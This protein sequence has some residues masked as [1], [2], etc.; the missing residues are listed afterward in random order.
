[1]KK[2]AELPSLI[3][4]ALA[5]FACTA[6]SLAQQ[7]DWPA[8]GATSGNSHYSSLAQINRSNAASLKESWRFDTGEAGGLETTPLVIDG[9][10]YGLTPSKKVFAIDA[11][12]GRQIWKFDSGV[13]APSASRGLNWW[14]S[15]KENRLLVGIANFLYAIDPATGKPIASFGTDGRIDL[16]EN[17][18]RPPESQSVSLN[19]P[20]VVYKDLI[21]V[22]SSLPE[23]IPAPPGD[24]RAYDVRTGAL[25]WSFHTIPHPGEPGYQTWSPDSWKT[26]GAANNWAGMALDAERG[27]V[28]VPTGS[29]V[30]DFYG[31][32]R[33]GDDLYANTLLALDATTG[34]LLWHF[35]GVHHD[36][37]DRDFPAPP[38]LLTVRRNGK[39]IPAVAQTTKQGILFVFDRV[40][41]KPI[42][43]IEERPVLASDIPG[44]VAAKTQPYPSVPEAFAPQTVTEANLTN[45]TPAAHA[46]AVERLRQVRSDGPYVPLSVGKDTLVTPSFE[47]G[48]EWGGPASDPSTGVVYINANNYA[49]LGML[50]SS[51]SDLP[52]RATY[53]SQCSVCHGDHRQG[54]P[55][56]F[57]SLNAV[58]KRLT[59]AQIS[60]TIHHGKGRMP[61]FPIEGRQLNDL[62]SYLE[63]TESSLEKPPSEQQGETSSAEKSQQK[64]DGQYT[65]TG[66]RRFLDPD[67]YPATATPWG[68]LNAIDLNTGKYLWK[69]PLGQYPEL[70]AQGL[71]DT[72]SENYGGPIVTA[73]GLLFIAATNFDHKIRAFDKTT[74]KLLWESTMP[75]AGN[76]T[77]VTYMVHG[78]QYIAIAAGGSSMNPRGP[79]GGVYIAFALP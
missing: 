15:G 12:T 63:T 24:I 19:S 9:V 69:L 26:S 28:Y 51:A 32:G 11:A 22:G 21:I 62:L 52:G 23:S 18:G 25:R 46:W 20:G 57:P 49:S 66:Y 48:A 16:R 37:W 59:A 10:L 50:I 34:K 43:P 35:Q 54:E 65:I 29:A 3:V 76:A 38:I 31:A 6:V 60:D 44:E 42:F 79:T 33:L 68:S 71:P 77:P 13:K 58:G 40:S 78:K 30:P 74:G 17:L 39:A 41:G 36:I 56:A 1:M 2:T 61:P 70:A 45:R 27:I 75:F 4:A 67:G 53:L 5:S 47:G 73:G 64:P 8:P 7:A 14:T 72:G 55:P